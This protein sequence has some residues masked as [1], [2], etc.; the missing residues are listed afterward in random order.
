MQSR[1]FTYMA[2]FF[3]RW[4]IQTVV[5]Q[6][7]KK[8]QI[9]KCCIQPKHN[10]YYRLITYFVTTFP[11]TNQATSKSALNSVTAVFVLLYWRL[12]YH[13]VF[14]PCFGLQKPGKIVKGRIYGTL[15]SDTL[16]W[17]SFTR[18]SRWM[19]TQYTYYNVEHKESA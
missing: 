8:R 2:S 7:S 9:R 12:L 11:R 1:H 6:K 17:L 14:S 13:C 19:L 4:Y 15:G 5:Y 3:N 16:R 18:D 10:D